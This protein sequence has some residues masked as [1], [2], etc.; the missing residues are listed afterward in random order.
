MTTIAWDGKT[1]AADKQSNFGDQKT[2]VTKIFRLSDG[3]LAAG[4]GEFS[5]ILSVIR[6]L[7]SGGASESFPAHQRDKDDW[8]PVLHITT[9][10]KICLYERT[11]FPVV[12]EDLFTAIG[13][14][15]AYALA[16]MQLGQTA[17]DAVVVASLFDPGTGRGVDALDLQR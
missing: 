7:D 15:K 2:T 1:L 16:A 4:S 6:W 11:P 12:R 10:G 13:S 8:Q 14:G 9:A 17:A 5:F 3:S